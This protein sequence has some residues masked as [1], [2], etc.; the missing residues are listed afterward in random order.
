[1]GFWVL[2]IILGLIWILLS[3]LMNILHNAAELRRNK[4]SQLVNKE[5][6]LI[7]KEME[8]NDRKSF[9]ERKL[10]ENYEAIEI[11]YKEKSPGFPWLAKAY[12][13]YSLLRDNIIADWL[14]KNL[15]QQLGLQK[16]CEM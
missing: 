5:N 13:E 16:S 7:E 2:V 4:K 1:M 11:L 3:A 10:N 6:E 12:S 9:I 8:F 14:E 15:I